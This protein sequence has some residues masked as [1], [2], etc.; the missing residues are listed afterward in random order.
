AEDEGLWERYRRV[1]GRLGLRVS[2][3]A[4]ETVSVDARV[5][6]AYL[7]GEPV[8]PTEAIFITDLYALPHQTVD[9]CNQVTLFT[10]LEQLGFHLPIPPSIACLTAEKAATLLFL[11]DCPA[12]PVPSVRI[13]AGRDGARAHYLP[14]LAG[15]AFPLL[16]K[17]A[18]WGT[19]IGVCVVRDLDAFQG[20]V[21]LAG[22]SDTALIVQPYFEDV[23]DYRVYLIEGRPHAALRT[24]K[25][26]GRRVAGYVE[27]PEEL[28]KAVSWI[29]SRLPLP[30]LAV[31]F[32]FD[33]E[34][35]WLSEVEPDGAVEPSDDGLGDALVMRRFQAYLKALGKKSSM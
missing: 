4:P 26:G 35:F 18:Y 34:R 33:G 31:D 6:L 28:R 23:V 19:G 29:S 20:V 16:V 8:T 14:A 2:V 22:G 9:V 17:P 32:L 25:A 13:C 10:V 5:P 3:H 30:Y 11:R 21:S 15:L 27:V 1:A 7:D 24:E 12:P